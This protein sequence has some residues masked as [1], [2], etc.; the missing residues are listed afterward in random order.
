MRT[1]NHRVLLEA[2]VENATAK[3]LQLAQVRFETSPNV[4]AVSIHNSASISGDL[5]HLKEPDTWLASYADSLQVPTLSTAATSLP[6][7]YFMPQLRSPLR[8]CRA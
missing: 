4:T 2:C 6:W 8:S 3:P 5:E 1:L 7:Q